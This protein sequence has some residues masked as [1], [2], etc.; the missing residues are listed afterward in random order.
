MTQNNVGIYAS[1]I[2][3][4]LYGGPYGAYDSLATVTLSASATSITFAGIPSGYKHL[5]IR[6]IARNTSAGGEWLSMDLNGTTATYRH[7]LVG[8]GTSVIAQSEANNSR[9][10]V[11]VVQGS[12]ASNTF[13]ASIIDI[14][15]YSSTTKNKTVRALIGKDLN[16]ADSGYISLG[17][18]FFNSTSAIT[19][20]TLKPDEN[21]FDIYTQFALYGVK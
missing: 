6:G 10:G 9:L 12:L 3:G 21:S 7:L 18:T 11:G 2:S 19:S 14:L 8:I 13:G 1:Q 20:I 16:N 4:H 15:D 5:Q 17:S